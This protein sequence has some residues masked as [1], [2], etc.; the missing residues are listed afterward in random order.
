M[1]VRGAAALG[2]ELIW[3]EDLNSGQRYEGITVRNPFA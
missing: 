3:T 2:A 1:I